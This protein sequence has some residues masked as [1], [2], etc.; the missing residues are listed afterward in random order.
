MV[1]VAVTFVLDDAVT[2][3]V[4]V[5]VSIVMVDTVELKLSVIV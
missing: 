4:I 2:F 3:G 5:A 1:L